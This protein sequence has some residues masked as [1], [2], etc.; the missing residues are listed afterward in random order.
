MKHEK[1]PGLGGSFTRET[2]FDMAAFNMGVT[3][4]GQPPM[5]CLNIKLKNDVWVGYAIPEEYAKGMLVRLQEML[6]IL[7]ERPA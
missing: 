5:V 2:L 3:T 6:R 1:D 7:G 4:P